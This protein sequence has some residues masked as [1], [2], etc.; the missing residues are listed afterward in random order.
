M[1][2]SHHKSARG[3]VFYNKLSCTN[4]NFVLFKVVSNIF[5]LLDPDFELMLKEKQDKYHPISSNSHPLATANKA[6]T[7]T[8]MRVGVEGGGGYKDSN[9][10][11]SAY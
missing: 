7:L 3:I 6:N 4:V 8:Q 1:Q 5:S 9:T 10:V 11:H 2:I